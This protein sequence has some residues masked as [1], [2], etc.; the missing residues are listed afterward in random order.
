M[1]DR[2][3]TLTSLLFDY[4][5]PEVDFNKFEVDFNEFEVNFISIFRFQTFC[6]SRGNI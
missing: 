3:K 5:E 4:N 6:V 2:I 1:T